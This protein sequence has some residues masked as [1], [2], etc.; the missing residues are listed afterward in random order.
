MCFPLDLSADALYNL[1]TNNIAVQVLQL[2]HA[3]PAFADFIPKNNPQ[4]HPQTTP[5][6]P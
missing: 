5:T 4:N 1:L 6:K 2:K 3:F